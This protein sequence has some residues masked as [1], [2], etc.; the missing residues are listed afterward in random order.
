MTDLFTNNAL[1][2]L[3][4]GY[5]TQ[6]GRPARLEIDIP[7]SLTALGV[8]I[9]TVSFLTHPLMW[10]SNRHE[11][12]VTALQE[13]HLTLGI[14]EHHRDLYGRTDKTLPQ[15]FCLAALGGMECDIS[16]R[17]YKRLDRSGKLNLKLFKA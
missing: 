7:H 10:S 3:N 8:T 16:S 5:R 12:V 14:D 9:S 2:M 6:G 13:I 11:A 15:A 1:F 17:G 4:V